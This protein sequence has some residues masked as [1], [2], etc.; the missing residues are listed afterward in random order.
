MYQRPQ[1]LQPPAISI[2]VLPNPRPTFVSPPS[3][4]CHALLTELLICVIHSELNQ[5]NTHEHQD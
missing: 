3:H 4:A 5:D 1:S 2:S